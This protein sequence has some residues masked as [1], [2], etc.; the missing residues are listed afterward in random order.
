MQVPTYSLFSIL[1]SS[2]RDTTAVETGYD[3]C[4]CGSPAKQQPLPYIHVLF[5]ARNFLF[6]RRLVFTQRRDSTV[7]Q[8]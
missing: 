7:L 3:G 8:G 1:T 6:T 5:I 4:I 2:L